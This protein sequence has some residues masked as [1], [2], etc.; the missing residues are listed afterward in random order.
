MKKEFIM[1]S[2]E[3]KK[4]N[5]EVVMDLSVGTNAQAAE[6]ALKNDVNI[7]KVAVISL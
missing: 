5:K 4:F 3:M 1:P 6:D 7:N 2:L